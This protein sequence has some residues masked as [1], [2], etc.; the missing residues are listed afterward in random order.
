MRILKISIVFGLIISI[1]M[2]MARFDALCSD[3]RKNIFRLHIKAASDSAPDQSLKLMVRDALLNEYGD[4]FINC[5]NKEEAINFAT[6]NIDNFRLTAEKII[7]DNGFDYGV[8]VNVGENY[9]ENREYD[10]FTLPA[11]DY[12]SLNIIIDEGKGKNWWCVMFPAVCLGASC[13]LNDAVDDKSAG[14]AEN[15]SDF[16]IRFKTVE[17]YEDFKKIFKNRKNK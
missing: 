9:F 10:T 14:I 5:S 8:S 13:S 4:D 16:K 7:K 15:S 3:L 12:E 17:I 2:S 1:L 6:A 11:G